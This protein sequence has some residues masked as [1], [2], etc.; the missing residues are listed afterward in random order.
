MQNEKDR[1]YSLE[2]LFEHFNEH[3]ELKPMGYQHIINILANDHLKNTDQGVGVLLGGKFAWVIVS[4]TYEII[5]PIKELKNLFGKTWYAGRRGPFYRREY[6][7]LD[8]NGDVLVKAGSYSILMDLSNR[9]IYRN[10]ELPFQLLV[11]NNEYLLECEPRLKEVFDFDEVS[12]ERRV[13]SSYLDPIGHVNNLRYPE[14]VYDFFNEEEIKKLGKIKRIEQYFQKELQKDETFVVKKV[15]L[16]KR[17]VFEVFNT[18][19][20]EKAFTLVLHYS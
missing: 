9:S 5:K 11:E 14:V 2:P 19:T 10:K 7:V 12:K 20:N 3:H 15:N 18:E 16:E 8:E 13:Y 4:L 17:A 6:L 1:L